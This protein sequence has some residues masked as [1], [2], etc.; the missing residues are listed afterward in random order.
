MPKSVKN[1]DEFIFYESDV[2]DAYIESISWEWK[3]TSFNK[4]AEGKPKDDTDEEVSQYFVRVM[5]LN[6]AASPEEIGAFRE[7]LSADDIHNGLATS[8]EI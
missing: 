7:L 3:K 8:D 1:V 6:T 4:K 2:K 5:I